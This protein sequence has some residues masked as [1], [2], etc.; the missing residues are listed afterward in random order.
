M[1]GFNDF[2]DRAVTRFIKPTCPNHLFRYDA[3][4]PGRHI[5]GIDHIERLRH[6]DL[7]ADIDMDLEKVEEI[8]RLHPR[9]L[10]KI[11][12]RRRIEK[13]NE[14]LEYW[15]AARLKSGCVDVK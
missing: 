10:N 9:A 3:W 8:V 1:H 14:I 13:M 12:V 2:R 6:R 5:I 7:H 4:N 15:L 11:R